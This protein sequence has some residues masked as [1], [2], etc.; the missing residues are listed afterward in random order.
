METLKGRGFDQWFIINFTYV[1]KFDPLNVEII[2]KEL[3]KSINVEIS[4]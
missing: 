2:L 3:L 4:K 1:T